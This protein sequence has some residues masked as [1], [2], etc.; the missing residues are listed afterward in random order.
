MQV[1]FDCT[2]P[3]RAAQF[4]AAAIGYEVETNPD[5]IQKLLDDG[6]ITDADVVEIDGVLFFADA[7][8]ANDV[9]GDRPRLLFQRVPEDKV[10]KNRC[11]L[12]IQLA[13]DTS[14]EDRAAEE[15]RLIGLGATRLGDGQQGGHT[16]VILAD[17]EGNEFC[18]G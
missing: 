16:W 14:P 10:A 11:H 1:V 15:Q 6:M 8:A 12:D 5:F 4:W 7:V 9:T 3:H 2:D 18:L 13:R 17:P